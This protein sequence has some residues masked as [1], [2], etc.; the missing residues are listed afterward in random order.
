MNRITKTTVELHPT[1]DST[2]Y[3]QRTVCICRTTA[4]TR[5]GVTHADGI[6]F[7]TPN[8]SRKHFDNAGAKKYIMFDK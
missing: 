1:R 8:A 7:I 4:T 5:L 6:P 2:K 3:Q